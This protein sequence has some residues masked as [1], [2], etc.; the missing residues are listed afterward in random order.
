M[1]KRSFPGVPPPG[2]RWQRQLRNS[3]GSTSIEDPST[4]IAATTVDHPRSTA[5]R[6]KRIAIVFCTISP[7]FAVPTPRM[8]NAR[9]FRRSLS[10]LSSPL[11]TYRESRPPT[12]RGPRLRAPR[13][14][15]PS[16]VQF[17]AISGVHSSLIARRPIRRDARGTR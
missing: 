2:T 12:I 8:H 5:S 11:Y 15:W 10:A 3:H 4:R 14:D 13:R 9:S 16:G 6:G 1:R 17:F 7:V